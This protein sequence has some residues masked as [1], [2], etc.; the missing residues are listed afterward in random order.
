MD[1]LTW[2]LIGLIALLILRGFFEASR[3]ALGGVRRQSLRDEAETGDQ[4]AVYAL[5]IA[6][7]S[8]RVLN[9]FRLATFL[10]DFMLA[11]LLAL[12]ILPP[13]ADWLA[14]VARL[15]VWAAY[16]ISYVVLILLGASLVYLLTDVM[17]SAL[18]QRNMT[19]SA[20]RLARPAHLAQTLLHPAVSAVTALRHAMAPPPGANGIPAA[21]V[22]EEEIMT[23]VDAGEEEGSI[24]LEEKEMIYS[25]FQLDETLAREIMVPRIDMIA[26]EMNTPLADARRVIIEAGH[27]RI[28]VYE[29]SL[30]RVKGLLYAKDLLEVWEKGEET[31]DMARLLRPAFFIPESKRVSDLL[32]ELQQSKVHIAIVI[33]EYGGTAGLVT[34]EDIVEEIVGEIF[35]EYDEEVDLPYEALGPDEY[36]FDGRIDLDDFNRLLDTHLP[37]ELGD[38]LGGFIYGRLGKVPDI[39]EMIHT[40]RLNIEVLEVS[41][42]RIRKVRVKLISREEAA[43]ASHDESDGPRHASSANGR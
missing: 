33:D 37:T 19:A 7:D 4:D 5:T 29:E 13:V 28:P 1:L 16:V 35:D 18:V 15:Q 26:V 12:V 23:L 30:D 25:I 38:T 21:Q 43:A 42:R 40:D 11:A 2:G 24:E 17:P 36:T 39:G 20:K 9:T 41:D 32:H 8:S 34:I 22:T 10:T 3:T 6:E 27:S 14:G 31:F